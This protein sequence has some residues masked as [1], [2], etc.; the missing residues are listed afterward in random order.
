MKKE[1]YAMFP[2]ALGLLLFWL[3]W[4][5]QAYNMAITGGLVVLVCAVM[6][7]GVFIGLTFKK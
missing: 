6:I 3:F 5:N 2:T 4:F 1:I 7:S